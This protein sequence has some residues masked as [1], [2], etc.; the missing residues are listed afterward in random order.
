MR[1]QFTWFE[2]FSRAAQRIKNKQH[3]CSFYDIVTEYALYEKEPD[4]DS[5]PDSVA[6]AFE[7]IKPNLDASKRKA[8]SGKVGGSNKQTVNKQEANCKQNGSKTEANR[9]QTVSEKE[10]EKENE[11]EYEIEGEDECLKKAAVASVISAYANKVNANPGERTISEIKGFVQ[12]M[13]AECCLRAIDIALDE[14]KASWS[15]IRG[16]LRSKLEQGVHSLADWDALEE[17]RRQQ[18]DAKRKGFTPISTEPLDVEPVDHIARMQ[19]LIDQ[20]KGGADD[21]QS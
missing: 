9:K 14:R 6:I 13:G 10:N 2:S 11:K 17:K 18:L 4:M 19:W 5:L 1:T 7:L 21:G 16:I 8:A 15:Y 20:M 12:T 3:R